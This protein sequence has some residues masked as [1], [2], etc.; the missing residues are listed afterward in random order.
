MSGCHLAEVSH[1][2][3]KL[4]QL[5]TDHIFRYPYIVVALAIVN[6]KYEAHEVRQYRCAAG[7][8][9]DRRRSLARLRSNYWETMR[10]SVD[11][12]DAD[13]VALPIWTTLT[14]QYEVLRLISEGRKFDA[15][16]IYP[17]FH[18]ERVKSA[19]VGLI[20]SQG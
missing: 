20:A 15:P 5:V 6:L 7:L 19:V 11:L 9:F 3:C 4:S 16:Y 12:K 8:G 14:G 1:S 13:I 2:R 17:P 18:T 10:S